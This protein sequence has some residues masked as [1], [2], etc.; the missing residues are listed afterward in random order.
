[1]LFLALNNAIIKVALVKNDLW[2]ANLWMSIVT[3]MVLFPTFYLFNKD[4]NKLK[5]KQK[6]LPL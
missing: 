1:M 4:I 6:K 3:L 5:I 2:T